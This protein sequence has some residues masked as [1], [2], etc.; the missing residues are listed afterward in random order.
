MRPREVAAELR[1]FG[2]L[3][4]LAGDIERS[5]GTT[6]DWSSSRSVSHVIGRIDTTLGILE[7]MRT[8]LRHDRASLE[9]EGK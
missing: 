7:D 6:E 8:K 5:Y 4:T 3:D 2:N 9:L 1:L